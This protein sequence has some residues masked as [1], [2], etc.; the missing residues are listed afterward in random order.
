[1]VD[2]FQDSIL[3]VISIVVEVGVEEGGFGG[4]VYE[5]GVWNGV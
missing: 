3:I 1:M 2:S 5:R 4:G